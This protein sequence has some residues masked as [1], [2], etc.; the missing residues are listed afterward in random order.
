M[1]FSAQSMCR[2]HG[3]K[4]ERYATAAGYNRSL[5]FSFGGGGRGVDSSAVSAF[6]SCRGRTVRSSMNENIK[7]F[8]GVTF[9][10]PS[11][12]YG[13]IICSRSGRCAVRADATSPTSLRPACHPRPSVGL[14]SICP[15]AGVSLELVWCG[16][17][18]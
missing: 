4:S 2:R 5:C 6:T 15:P 12:I 9:L 11:P 16:V 18:R 10:F 7:H 13:C 3:G 17:L 8:L 1:F 14:I